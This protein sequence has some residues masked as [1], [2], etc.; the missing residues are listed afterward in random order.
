MD[1]Q[2]LVAVLRRHWR[3][4]A[5]MTVLGALAA[6]AFTATQERLYTAETTVLVSPASAQTTGDLNSGATLVERVVQTYAELARTPVV[7]EPVA[8]GLG[9][10]PR[11]LQSATTAAIS[12]GTTFITIGVTWSSPEIAAE[13][14]NGIGSGLADAVEELAPQQAGQ[15]SIVVSTIT[16][17]AAPGSASSPDLTTNVLIGL[18]AGL[19]VGL[20]YV[21]LRAALD[22][23]VRTAGDVRRITSAPLL[24][25][26]SRSRGRGRSRGQAADAPGAEDYRRVRTNLRLLDAT[27]RRG[28][29]V[30]TSCTAQEGTTAFA[31]NLARTAVE[32]GL[33]VCLVE[34]DL[35]AQ[36][37]RSVLRLP[38]GPGLADVLTGAADLRSAT[39]RFDGVDVVHAGSPAANPGDLVSSPAMSELMRE[40]ASTHDLVIC[41]AAPLLSA[42]DGAALGASADGVVLVV[43]NQRVSRDQLAEATGALEMAGAR[44]LGVVLNEAPDTQ[45][46]PSA[47]P[48]RTDDGGVQAA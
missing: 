14:A 41:A 2:E 32:G 18:I 43:G 39:H 4:I 13:A 42:T 28:A 10:E 30:V 37:L 23:R 29:L 34:A 36:H 35:R 6:W 17:A 12:S 20:G 26:I 45:L 24:G 7:L 19:L 27:H 11:E 44:L 9:M 3:P 8:Q 46:R 31:I 22:S 15:P 48:L 38:E 1:L 16:P 5:A 21:I 47:T 25:T 33:R 40:L